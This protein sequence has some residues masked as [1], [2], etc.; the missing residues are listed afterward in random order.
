V[1]ATHA[2]RH[3]TDRHI[4]SPIT[5]TATSDMTPSDLDF[6]E[7]SD[8][9]VNATAAIDIY[10][11]YSTSPAITCTTWPCTKTIVSTLGGTTTVTAELAYPPDP[12]DTA[13]PPIASATTTTGRTRT[14][15]GGSGKPCTT[16]TCSKT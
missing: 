10:L 9:T 11:G 8:P 2:H 3:V 7:T 15:T 16:I 1:R 6:P 13:Q 14:G 12:G 4:G 5:I